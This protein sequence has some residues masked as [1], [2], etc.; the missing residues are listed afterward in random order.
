MTQTTNNEN[1]HGYA[2]ARRPGNSS[3]QTTPA[4]A[5]DATA[6]FAS[7]G[8]TQR[9][10]ITPGT[11]GP[12]ARYDQQY[13]PP[14]APSGWPQAYQ[15]P[16]T[17]AAPV[18][19]YTGAYAG[20][21]STTSAAPTSAWMPGDSFGQST[22]SGY[23]GEPPEPPV[24]G[25]R[26]PRRPGWGGVLAV[27]IGAAALSSLL[28]A[29]LVL[30]TQDPTTTTAAPTSNTSTV[31][32]P[33]TSS[34]TSSPDWGA[35]S[36]AVM[37]SVV[38][39][40]VTGQS[41]SGEGSGVI[42]DKTGRIVTN[43]HVVSGVGSGASVQVVLSDGRNYKATVL[44]TDP[45]TDLAVIQVTDPPSDLTPAVLGE[46]SAVAVGD[47]V[48]AVGN[49]LGLAGTVTTGIVSATD[50]PAVT[51]AESSDPTSSGGETVV[52][53][54]IQTDAAVNPG[55]SGGALVDAQGRVI[56]IPSS[57]ASLSTG[58][59]LGGQSSQSG[60]IGLGFAIPVD[61][62]KDVTSQLIKGG[63]VSHA[64]LGVGPDDG[65]ATSDGATRDAAVL[66]QILSGGPAEKAGLKV[67]DAVIAVDGDPVNSSLSLVG[68]LRER[69]TG[70]AVT[71][72]VVRDGKTLNVKVTLGTKPA[73]AN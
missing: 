63:T 67:G 10:E 23:G 42:L 19:S 47:P 62:V 50:R 1:D 69:Q 49:P 35:V 8:G 53:N 44:G 56:G 15:V 65:T 25:R 60:S 11:P 70:T 54:S 2:W 27:G 66:K 4:P 33:V 24:T 21:A 3:D 18:P 38:A 73:S 52:T 41:G 31:K 7:S 28:T 46:S 64:W 29:G 34:S 57:I 61:E 68:Q 55:N 72:T 40:K 26:Q 5:A 51:Q 22:G 9:T 17:A 43:N 20:Q 16:P 30:Q 6:E 45:S 13:Q 32:A 71:L 59:S 39:V 37:P 12:T 14:S 48:M 58:S 36:K